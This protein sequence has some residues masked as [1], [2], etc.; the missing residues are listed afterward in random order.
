MKSWHKYL[1]KCQAC[2]LSQLSRRQSRSLNIARGIFG[3][4]QLH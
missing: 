1:W 4:T 3:P 2:G